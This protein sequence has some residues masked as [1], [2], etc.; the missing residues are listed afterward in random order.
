MIHLLLIFSLN[1]NQ[2][3]DTTKVFKPI[4]CKLKNPQKACAKMQLATD[5][6]KIQ[7]KEKS[8]C[9]KK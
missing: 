8:C 5:T 9:K 4:C 6:T 2:P 3:Q 1:L 7:P